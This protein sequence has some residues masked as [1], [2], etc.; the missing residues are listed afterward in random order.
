MSIE[1]L[2]IKECE[3]WS[4]EMQ[5]EAMSSLIAMPGWKLLQ[6]ILV[7]GERAQWQNDLNSKKHE[8]LAEVEALQYKISVIDQILEIPHKIME[9]PQLLKSSENNNKDEGRDPYYD[10][11]DEINNDREVIT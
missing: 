9:L 1:N 10:T 3:N 2:N 8:S 11:I 6:Y 5:A 4:H 7:T